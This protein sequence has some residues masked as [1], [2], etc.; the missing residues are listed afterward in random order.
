MFARV[1]HKTTQAK[2]KIK[3]PWYK[4]L[5]YVF[6][7][8]LFVFIS[9]AAFWLFQITRP[10]SA[11]IS[12]VKIFASYQHIPHQILQN[13]INP[14]LKNGFFYLNVIG[15][16][17]KLLSIP[18]VDKVAIQREWPSTIA[19][20]IDEQK[21]IA[22]WGDIALFNADGEMYFPDAQTFPH[23]IPLLL[24]PSEQPKIVF[25]QYKA[26]GNI[27]ATLG[28]SIQEISLSPQHFWHLTL[29]SGT[30]LFLGENEANEQL[31]ELL[32]F[33]PK[34]MLDHDKPPLSIDLRYKNGLAVKWEDDKLTNN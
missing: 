9:V 5:R 13:A 10:S 15:L 25:K 16:K 12:R 34:I 27:L 31:Q 20:V 2:R 11:P 6:A 26:M 28:L 30:V 4:I 23:D 14:Y 17:H 8:T 22:R 21:P 19:V 33:Y 32:K 7:F 1:G 3:I 24:G 18:W 29:N